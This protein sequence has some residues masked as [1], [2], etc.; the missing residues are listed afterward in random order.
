MGN[1]PVGDAADAPWANI[2]EV[3]MTA[4]GRGEKA[5][6]VERTANELAAVVA[7][8][9]AQLAELQQHVAQR[10][11]RNEQLEGK[12]MTRRQEINGVWGEVQKI[13]QALGLP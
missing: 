5:V 1:N 8:Q 4:P 2:P 10:I 12:I 3:P 7:K 6:R 11:A 9:D 13:K